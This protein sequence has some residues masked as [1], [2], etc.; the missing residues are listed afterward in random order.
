MACS[1]VKNKIRLH[2]VVLN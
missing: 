1:L 2:G